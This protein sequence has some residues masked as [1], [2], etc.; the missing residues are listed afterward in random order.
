MSRFL[1]RMKTVDPNYGSQQ[2]QRWF[3]A[4][5]DELEKRQ[6]C[7]REHPLDETVMIRNKVIP[8]YG[9]HI[10]IGT[11]QCYSAETVAAAVIA[12]SKTL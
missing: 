11:R 10:I 9:E 12:V 1:T 5:L 4:F 3:L 2:H 7:H 6:P 8:T